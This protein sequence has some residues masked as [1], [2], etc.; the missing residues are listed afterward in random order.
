M[1]TDDPTT[2]ADMAAQAEQDT[3]P[4]V[5]ENVFIGQLKYELCPG[6]L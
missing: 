4:G 3:A 2:E 1:Q 5:D 6:L